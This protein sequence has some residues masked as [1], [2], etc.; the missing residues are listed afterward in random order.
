MRTNNW[1]SLFLVIPLLLTTVGCSESAPASKPDTSRPAASPQAT[2][3][4]TETTSTSPEAATAKLPAPPLTL[5]GILAYEE[6]A[7]PYAGSKYEESAVKAEL[8][9]ISKELSSEEVYASILQIV[10]ENYVEEKS[11][12]EELEKIDYRQALLAINP[13]DPA[14]VTPSEPKV[15]VEVVLDASGSMAQKVGG[16]VKMDL[17]KQ[18][19]QSFL[20]SLPAHANVGLRVFGHKGSGSDKDKPLSCTQT[21]LIYPLSM[22]DAG[23]FQ[24]SLQQFGPKGWTGIA[25]ALQAARQD[26]HAAHK[27]GMENVIYLVTDG[28]ETCGGN[29]VEVARSLHQ[30]EIKAVINLIGFDVDDEA[31]RQ[32]KAVA[33][34]GGGTYTTVKDKQALE[35]VFE[36][37]LNDLYKENSNWMQQALDRV[38]SEYEQDEKKLSDTRKTMLEKVEVEYNRLL[39]AVKYVSDKDIID[40]GKRSDLYNWIDERWYV[41]S[42]YA[43]DRW[44]TLGYEMD[45]EWIDASS[46]VESQW[47]K[48][49]SKLDQKSGKISFRVPGLRAPN[50][51]VKSLRTKP[52]RYEF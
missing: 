9:K 42:D 37:Y 15:N 51:R 14:A 52:I 22:Y 18:S 39:A 26:L 49:G 3:S 10:G 50:L 28:I 34:A 2:E 17:A 16:G 27:D 35:K 48:N 11:I 25:N 45:S 30:S 24:S 47:M 46:E 1:L 19:I 31:Q 21:D 7:G 44:V 43:D 6:K 12:F 13:G 40:K 32:L 36:Q 33:E 41:L 8:D 4:T 20:G 38:Y 29:P 23:R 5:E